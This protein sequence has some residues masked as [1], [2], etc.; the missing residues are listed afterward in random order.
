MSLLGHDDVIFIRKKE[1]R[2]LGECEIVLIFRAQHENE[3]GAQRSKKTVK[4]KCQSLFG[5][6]TGYKNYIESNRWL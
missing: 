6:L 2:G 1:K 4:R 5:L 3:V